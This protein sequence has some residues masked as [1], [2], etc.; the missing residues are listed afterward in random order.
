MEAKLQKKVKNTRMTP[1]LGVA[2]KLKRYNPYEEKSLL[3]DNHD[4]TNLMET[5]IYTVEEAG[6]WALVA[7]P[8]QPPINK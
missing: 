7:G 4:D 8:K 1:K 3:I 6:A 5:P 2:K